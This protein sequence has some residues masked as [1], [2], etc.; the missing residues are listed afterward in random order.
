MNADGSGQT[1]LTNKAGTDSEPVFSP[2]G[3]KIVF[4]RS[5]L[6]TFEIAIMNT[7]GSGVVLLT[8]NTINDTDPA[9]QPVSHA[10]TIG[11]FR[12]S[13]SEFLLRNSNTSG[14][15]NTIIT[16]GQPSDLPVVGDWNGDG[17]T[18]VG[19]FR[20]GQF[21]LRTAIT[22]NILGH[23]QTF[24]ITTTINFGLAGD[25]PVAGDWDGDGIDTVGVFRNGQF[26]LTNS[27]NINNSSPAADIF[28][29]LGQA[30]DLPL[31]GDWNNDG[32][33]TIGVFTPSNIT[34]RLSNNFN[35]VVDIP[36]FPFGQSIFLPVSGD[37]DGDGLD[38]FGIFA[39]DGHFALKN[40]NATG[41]GNGD[42]VFNF[43]QAGDLPIAGD[44][45]AKP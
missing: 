12:P 2:D 22:I 26:Q 1:R 37:W 9:V 36:P 31:A 21:L 3:K 20:N 34:Y 13:T 24:V 32:I 11:V 30:G 18:D 33:D 43:G 27:K 10:D 29:L 40:V 23:P 45:D 17:I 15:A 41:S 7:D 25:L 8:N 6:I 38:S 4:N 42:I 19:V 16:F 14:R 35:G 39:P 28:V 44:W 5:G